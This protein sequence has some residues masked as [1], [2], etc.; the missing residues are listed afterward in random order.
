MSIRLSWIKYWFI[1]PSIAVGTNYA[2]CQSTEDSLELQ[3]YRNNLLPS[4]SFTYSPQT[5]VVLGVFALYQFKFDRE[6]YVTRPSNAHLYYGMSFYDQIIFNHRHTMLTNAE[7]YF[8]QGLIEYKFF[9]EQYYGI[10]NETEEKNGIIAEYKALEI[11]ERVFRQVKPNVFVGLQARYVNTF[12]VQFRKV[13]GD[14]IPPPQVTG[15]TGGDYLGLGLAALLDKRNS[16]LT[17]TTDF[18][19]EV[20]TY[21]YTPILGLNEGFATF[22]F[23][24]R[25]YFDFKSGGKH[26]LALQGKIRVTAGTVPFREYALIG[27]KEILRGYL[28]G[29]FRDFN[30][31]QLQSE[32]RVNLIGRFGATTFVGLGNVLPKLGDIDLDKMK[33][34]AGAGLRFNIN[35]KDPTNVRIDFGWSL[36]DE[37]KGLY[38]T[39]GE[40][41]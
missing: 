3:P 5:D 27:G 4:P 16:I 36:V 23:D 13:N 6:D 25:K 10:G 22:D 26:V 21:F 19:F 35:R 41:F 7:K 28:K 1:V 8:L 29:R 2:Y 38:I 11:Y 33:V 12:D 20:S 30:A 32:Y 15:N 17:P 18:Y 9:P 37:S 40:A 39:F 14:S 34:A 24:G 31:Y